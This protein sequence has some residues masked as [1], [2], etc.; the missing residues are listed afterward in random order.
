MKVEIYE[1][2]CVLSSLS[3]NLGPTLV[4][5]LKG[6]GLARRPSALQNVTVNNVNKA[7][8]LDHTCMFN[9]LKRTLRAFLVQLVKIIRFIHPKITILN[10][11]LYSL[12][13]VLI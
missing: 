1:V 11:F 5:H 7:K 9:K 12:L 13:Q 10:S 8:N 4:F 6:G 2:W 3:L